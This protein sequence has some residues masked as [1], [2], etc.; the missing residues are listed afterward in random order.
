MQSQDYQ[1]IGICLAIRDLATKC[2][3]LFSGSGF[4]INTNIDRYVCYSSNDF[5]IVMSGA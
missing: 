5:K 3:R 4:D 2:T 1:L